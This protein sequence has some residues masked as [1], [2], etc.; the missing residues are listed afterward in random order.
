MANFLIFSVTLL[1]A[2]FSDLNQSYAQ[3]YQISYKN[4][5]P[6][7][8]TSSICAVHNRG[9]VIFKIGEQSSDG[10]KALAEDGDVSTL[11]RELKNK[12]TFKATAL[13]EFVSKNSQSKISITSKGAKRISCIFGMLTA[14]NDAFVAVNSLKLPDSIGQ[15]VNFRAVAYDAG[16]E[17]NTESC[18]HVPGSPC[19]AHFIG[20]AENS[21]ISLHPGIQ[22]IADLSVTTHGWQ[23][24]SV[25]GSITRI[26]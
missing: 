22:G 25:R 14:T 5:T 3:T 12:S 1:L 9:S 13:G 17:V 20:I 10:L 19:D 8:L 24:P 15:K 18:S 23:E 2:M 6:Q 21:V 7:T 16:T 11:R 26:K 4:N